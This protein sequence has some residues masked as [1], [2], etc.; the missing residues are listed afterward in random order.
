M[1]LLL[2]SKIFS[3]INVDTDYN[4]NKKKK[5]PKITIKLCTRIGNDSIGIQLIKELDNVGIDLTSPLF[6]VDDTVLDTKLNTTTGIAT[7][8]TKK[9][10]STTSIATVIVATNDNSTN[11]NKNNNPIK[12]VDSTQT[13]E[14]NTSKAPTRTCIFTPGTCGELSIDDIEIPIDN[15]TKSKKKNKKQINTNNNN[16]KITMDDIFHGNVILLHC[17]GRHTDVALQLAKEANRRTIPISIDVEK[18]RSSKSLDELLIEADIIF[19]NSTHQMTTYLNRL[20]DDQQK[21]SIRIEDNLDIDGDDDT[22]KSSNDYDNVGSQKKVIPRTQEDMVDRYSNATI[23]VIQMIEN[24]DDTNR[25][26]TDDDSSSNNQFGTTNSVTSTLETILKSSDEQ[27]RR[28]RLLLDSIQFSNYFTRWYPN[29]GGAKNKQIITMHGHHGAVRVVTE[30]VQVQQAKGT[31]LT[32]NNKDLD[33]VDNNN[34]L[35]NENVII[36]LHDT[37][38][39]SIQHSFTTEAITQSDSNNS[40]KVGSIQSQLQPS[41]QRQQQKENKKIVELPK[42]NN[43]NLQTTKIDYSASYRIDTVGVLEVISGMSSVVVDTTGAGDAFIG[44]YLLSCIARDYIWKVDDSPDTSNEHHNHQRHQIKQQDIQ[45]HSP[46]TAIKPFTNYQCIQFATWVAGQ[47]VR[48]YGARSA[49]P[50]PSDV[51]GILGT[52][53]DQVQDYLHHSIGTFQYNC[54]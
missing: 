24:D 30:S 54:D 39:S 26:N 37:N 11:D 15:S 32:N 10:H 34:E 22:D 47:K 17:D 52:T 35:Q 33:N 21:N 23:E 9:R 45:K 27:Y 48:G 7:T 13:R 14:S 1:A 40:I 12:S 5:I 6:Q 51:D 3:S 42:S 49:I 36:T 29:T 31:I 50:K 2:Q 18:D 19:T 4:S 43:D 16:N 20:N 41:E 46:K 53:I 25:S 38:H 8:T 44:A 28:I